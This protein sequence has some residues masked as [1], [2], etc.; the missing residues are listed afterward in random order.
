MH[1][2]IKSEIIQLAHANPT[3]EIC[4]FIVGQPA[5]PVLF[6][7]RNVASNPAEQFDIASDDHIGAMSAGRLLAVYHSHPTAAAF[8]PADLDFA[9]PIALPQYLYSV[10]D[11]AWHEYIPSTHVAPM[12]GVPFCLGFEDCYSYVRNF[13]RQKLKHH[14]SDYDRDESFVHEEQEV[15]MQSFDREGFRQIQL[16]ELKPNDILLFRSNKLVPQHFGVF[17]GTQR[18][19]HHPLN[20]L[21]RS[22][23]ITDR[24]LD[25]LVCAFRLKTDSF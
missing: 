19:F 1:T 4:G 6:P 2:R 20:K 21:S 11:Q 3:E 22:E 23:Q 18:F 10:P 12:E 14:M 9:D 7:C 25:R 15:I 13:S 17:A 8:S 16:A 5:G 24:W